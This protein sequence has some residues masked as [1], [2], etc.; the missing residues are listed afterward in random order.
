MNDSDKVKM[1]INIAGEHIP[2]SVEF[3]RQNAVRNAEK[4]ADSLFQTWRKKWPAKSDKEL[5][6]MVAYQFASYYHELIERHENAALTAADTLARLDKA[7][8]G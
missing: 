2:L 5:L 3:D 1:N 6:A 4:A 8:N 7:L